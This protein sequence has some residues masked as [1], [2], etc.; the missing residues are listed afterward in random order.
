M[1]ED[2]GM[3]RRLRR[4]AREAADVLTVLAA[5]VPPPVVVLLV[6]ACSLYL[7]Y[8][9]ALPCADARPDD[10]EVWRKACYND[11]QPLYSGRGLNEGLVPYFGHNPNDPNDMDVEYPVLIAAFMAVVGL[12]IQAL[13]ASGR[14]AN[15]LHSLGYV[16]VDE[17]LVFFWVT[18]AVIA[19][20]AVITTWALLECRR[21][22]PWDVLLW[23]LAPALMLEATINWD[24]L[25][26]CLTVI[27]LAAWS[28]GRPG[29]AGA[30]LGL[31][32]AA[33]LYPLLILGPLVLLC[34]RA[35]TPRARAAAVRLVASS[36][37]AWLAVNLPAAL[38]AHDG[39]SFTYRFSQHR[40]IDWGSFWFVLDQIGGGLGARPLLTPLLGTYSALNR[41]SLVLFGLCCLG[42]AA[43]VWFA[44]RRPRVGAMA[45]LVVGAFLLTNKVW[46]PQFVLWLLPLAVLARP[47]WGWFLLWQAAETTYLFAV[48]RAV[49]GNRDGYAL[50]QASALRWTAVA[51]LCGV[52]VLEALHPERDVVR[53]G[54]ADDPEG[55]ILN[56]VPDP[57]FRPR[58]APAGPEASDVRPPAS[59]VAA[60][61]WPGA[62]QGVAQGVSQ[63]VDQGVGPGVTQGPGDGADPGPVPAV[64]PRGR[65]RG[66]R[67]VAAPRG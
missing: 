62:S 16:T 28:R 57:P 59:G 4:T 2:A 48:M 65:R 60:G 66:G 20:L 21:T 43:L 55:G 31:G 8:R 63:G 3:T 26:V 67:R 58:H 30:F 14:L 25:A 64:G 6:T 61:I 22:R 33:K 13:G 24:M 50:V 45:F 29:W 23:A 36:T 7:A 41:S 19:V 54:G 40:W 51:V 46:S 42:I 37:M 5:R 38:F 27:A 11:I 15:I 10:G 9:H 53:A 18:V 49:L 35:G 52:V 17:G 47:R 56:E 1:R 34:L 39:W 32:A 12:P 44:P